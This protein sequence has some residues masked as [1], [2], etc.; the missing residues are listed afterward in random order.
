MSRLVEADALLICVPTPL[1]PS[2][3]PDLIYVEQTARQ[4]AAH[5]RR[6]QLVSLEST[7]YPGTTRN[8]VLPILEQ[9]GLAWGASSIWR[10]VPSAKIRAIRTSRRGRFR[11]WW[12]G[13]TRR[14]ATGRGP[15]PA[16]DAR[17][18]CRQQLRGGRGLQDRGEHLPRGE[19]CAGERVE[20]VVRPNGNGR[21]GGD[22]GGENEALRLPGFLSRT[23]SW[24]VTA[25]RSTPSI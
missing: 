9:A 23:R 20:D 10:S 11:K 13:W 25:F 12:A 7:T 17:G 5:L 4:I 1:S 8:V 16:R 24:A 21:L 19:H 22:R 18:D 2:R 14:A 6:G 15:V 3:D